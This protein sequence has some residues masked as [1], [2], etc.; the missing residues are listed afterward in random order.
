VHG[1]T[2]I[3]FHVVACVLWDQGGGHDPA[4]ALFLGQITRAPVPTGTGLID[5]EQRLGLGQ[6]LTDQGLEVTLPGA[7]GAQ[8]DDLGTPRFRGIG[9]GDGRLVHLRTN[10]SCGSVTQS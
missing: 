10:V 1:V 9:H 3:S 4:A 8:Q 6:A 7:D 2:S 5:E